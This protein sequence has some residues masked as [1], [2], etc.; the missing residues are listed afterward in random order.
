MWRAQASRRGLLPQV[1]T[2][3]SN[4]TENVVRGAECMVCDRRDCTAMRQENAALIAKCTEIAEC[5]QDLADTAR[6]LGH[7][8]E[9]AQRE[10]YAY[11]EI[12]GALRRAKM[13]HGL[14]EPKE[15][16]A[17]TRCEAERRI[18]RM[19]SEYKGRRVRLA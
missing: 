4:L 8:L 17:C 6:R 14:C 3:M 15:R 19:L 11:H 16:H 5:N 18:E 7:A 13:E 2:A 1:Q 10:A 12:M 9:E